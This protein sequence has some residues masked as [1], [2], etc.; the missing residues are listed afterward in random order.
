MK[1]NRIALKNPPTNKDVILAYGSIYD[2]V[3]YKIYDYGIFNFTENELKH[4]S[5]SPNG[6]YCF[7]RGSA[8]SFWS[9][10]IE[11][12]LKDV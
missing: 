9:E 8:I 3:D 11:P 4:I 6:K 2:F 5:I 12:T 10:I 7:F 1:W